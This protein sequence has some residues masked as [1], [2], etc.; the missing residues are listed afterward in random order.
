M[1]P[2]HLNRSLLQAAI[3]VLACLHAI[4]CYAQISTVAIQQ[5]LEKEI[6]DKQLNLNDP[7]K[8]KEFYRFYHYKTAWVN[9]QPFRRQLYE[10][11]KAADELG[12]KKEDYHFNFIVSVCSGEK[13]LSTAVDSLEAEFIFTDGAIHFF[14]EAAYGSRPPEL[15]FNGLDYSPSCLNISYLLSAA[16]SLNE[17]NT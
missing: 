2:V 4:T 16:L 14:N 9:H 13:Q 3:F 1:K 15:R 5:S 10:Y 11:L 12:L 8:V 7:L 17:L 6:T